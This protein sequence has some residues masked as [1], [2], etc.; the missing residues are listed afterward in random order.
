MVAL[1]NRTLTMQSVSTNYTKRC[2]LG[3][4]AACS[5]MVI[6]LGLFFRK[7]QPTN[8]IQYVR[9]CV[10]WQNIRL[11]RKTDGGRLINVKLWVNYRQESYTKILTN[12]CYAMKYK[13]L[14]FYLSLVWQNPDFSEL[15]W[16]EY[17]GTNMFIKQVTM[18]TFNKEIFLYFLEVNRPF[19]QER[20]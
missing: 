3:F 7:R 11:A 12:Y 19:L 5:N 14:N 15:G 13:R 18:T 1:L 9:M 8:H 10:N 2:L 17:M 6:D 4:P 20:S 16:N